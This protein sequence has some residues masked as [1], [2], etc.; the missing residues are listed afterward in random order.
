MGAR[1]VYT[2]LVRGLG[3]Y[4][5]S[6]SIMIIPPNALNEQRLDMLK[7]LSIKSPF[8]EENLG[9]DTDSFDP[10]VLQWVLLLDID[11]TDL[12]MAE[13]RNIARKLGWTTRQVLSE[14]GAWRNFYGKWLTNTKKENIH[15]PRLEYTP[16]QR[17]N[18]LDHS[19]I[20]TFC[21]WS[22]HMS[23]GLDDAMEGVEGIT[24]SNI[25]GYT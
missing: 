3:H 14:K 1:I 24:K 5:Q 19:A 4:E 8:T 15:L 13:A 11:N 6:Q 23:Y 21:L 7:Q 20:P 25:F 18:L 2:H 16:G 9:T 17:P 12:D 22:F 10:L